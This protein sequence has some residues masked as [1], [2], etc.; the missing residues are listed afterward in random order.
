[1]VS[2]SESV[3][4]DLV[5]GIVDRFKPSLDLTVVRGP[6]DHV[7]Q[8]SRLLVAASGT[9]TL[10][11]ALHGIPTVIV[12]K[13]SPLS[14]AMG[15]R[16]IKVDHIGIVNL[17]V[18]KRLMPELIQDDV[19]PDTIAGTVLGMIDDPAAMR[20]IQHE[21]LG[22]R[23]RLGGPGASDRLARIALNLV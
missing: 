7:F 21:L 1:V 18:Q 4:S 3:D 6:V 14:Y 10:E 22:V 2:C 13:V 20:R 8:R 11:A 9:V 23:D 19:S 16:L 17:I 5:G 12:Y 15:K